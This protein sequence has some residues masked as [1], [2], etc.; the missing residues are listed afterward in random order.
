M[1]LSTMTKI[2]EMRWATLALKVQLRWSNSE[3]RRWKRIVLLQNENMQTLK[4][5]YLVENARRYIVME[6]ADS[7]FYAGVLFCIGF[8]I[9]AAFRRLKAL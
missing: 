8:G 1:D 5:L 4:N 3:M 7:H 2:A 6:R 9:A